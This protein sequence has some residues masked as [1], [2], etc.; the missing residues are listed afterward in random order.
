MGK[1]LEQNQLG[2]EIEK[3]RELL[4]SLMK[5]YDDNLH[6]PKVLQLSEELDCLIVNW[7]RFIQLDK[8]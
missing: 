4:K 3:K 5:Q 2:V 6:H 7:Q 8:K 1:N